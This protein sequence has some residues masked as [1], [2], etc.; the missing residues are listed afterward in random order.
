[1]GHFNTL[2]SRIDNATYFDHETNAEQF[3]EE[4]SRKYPEYDFGVIKCSLTLMP[5]PKS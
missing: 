2:T 5:F 4:L 1:M 3:A